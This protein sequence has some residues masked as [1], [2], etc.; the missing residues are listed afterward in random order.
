MAMLRS[1]SGCR[2]VS[3]TGREISS[4][5]SRNSTPLWASDISPGAPSARPRQAGHRHRVVRRPERPLANE[6][7]RAQHSRHRIHHRGLQSLLEAERRQD[8]G[9]AP[10]EHGLAQPVTIDPRAGLGGVSGHGETLCLLEAVSPAACQVVRSALGFRSC[11]QRRTRGGRLLDGR[12]AE[13]RDRRRVTWSSGH[14]ST[15]LL[16]LSRR[17]RYGCQSGPEAARTDS[18]PRAR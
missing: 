12:P 17:P 10:T 5:S 16:S 6:R 11:C 7:P 15:R 18:R 13:S 14:W 2:S 1:S 4:S 8:A 3:S 9:Q